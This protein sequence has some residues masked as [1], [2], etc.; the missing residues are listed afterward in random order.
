[1]FVLLNMAGASMA[2][3]VNV[4]AYRRTGRGGPQSAYAIVAALAALYVVSYGV[5]GFTDILPVDWSAVM[6]GVS[7][8]TWPFVWSIHAA[9]K[10]WSKQPQKW[11]DAVIEVVQQRLDDDV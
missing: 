9:S 10:V 5:L 1:M 4:L 3:V 6:R 7:V 11:A 8:L 2:S